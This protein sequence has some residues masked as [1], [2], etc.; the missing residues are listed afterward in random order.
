M[1]EIWLPVVGYEGLYEVS[2]LG[3]VKSLIRQK[4]YI[5]SL[6]NNKGYM[7]CTLKG[8]NKQLVHRLVAFAFI[9][10]I[11][12]KPCVNHI[13]GI[14][15]D[16]RVENLEWCTH[17]E[18]IIHKFE[19]LNYMPSIETRKKLSESGKGRFHSNE[20]KNK[21]SNWHIGKILSEDTK[22]KIS[23]AR[24]GK[25]TMDKNPTSKKVECIETGK[26]WDCAKQ[27]AIDTGINYSTLK[28]KLNGNH[29]NKTSLRYVD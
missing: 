20:T 18:N 2:S 13:N 23:E 29:L 11:Y 26:K 5:L 17:Q 4:D 9:H 12:N 1:Q 27:C 24:I 19:V 15:N 6:E 21:M 22:M 7:R 10:N 3:R 14:R 28:N 16:N 25:F 8:S